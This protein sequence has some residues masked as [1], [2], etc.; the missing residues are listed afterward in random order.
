[1]LLFD[2]TRGRNI[3]LSNDRCMASR[4]DTEF[5]QGYVF[6]ARPLLLGERIIIQVCLVT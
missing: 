5:C 3:R 1:M 4:T 6:T 2:R